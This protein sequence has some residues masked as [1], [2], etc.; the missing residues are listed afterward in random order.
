MRPAS[1]DERQAPRGRAQGAAVS[2]WACLTPQTSKHTPAPGA[3][4]LQ[5]AADF[6]GAFA[7]GFAVEDAI[8]LVRM[9]DLYVES[10]DVRLASTGAQAERR[11]SRT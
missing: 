1:A 3:Q 4:L 8:A 2:I 5:K 11:R 9:D 6:L 10:F 7:L